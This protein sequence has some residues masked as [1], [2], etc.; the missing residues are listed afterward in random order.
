LVANEYGGQALVGDASNT[1]PTSR[2]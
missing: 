1:V 2:A